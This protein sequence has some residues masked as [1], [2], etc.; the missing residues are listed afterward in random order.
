MEQSQLEDL[1]GLRA[2][3]WCHCALALVSLFIAAAALI[4]L[5]IQQNEIS[6]LT[7]QVSLLSHSKTHYVPVQ[8]L[9][10]QHP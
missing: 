2:D 6:H 1:K 10:T 9:T 4:W 8:P 7:N 5:T 3:M